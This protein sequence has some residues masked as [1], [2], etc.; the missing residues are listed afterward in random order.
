MV[1]CYGLKQLLDMLILGPLVRVTCAGQGQPVPVTGLG[2]SGMS[3][4]DPWLIVACAARGGAWE[5]PLCISRPAITNIRLVA[6]QQDTQGTP[7]P[8]T[9]SQLSISLSC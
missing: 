3:Y 9:T 4:S 2:I 5:R 1:F 6:A 8:A 7:K